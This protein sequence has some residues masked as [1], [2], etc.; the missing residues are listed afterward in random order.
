MS[1]VPAPGAEAEAGTVPSAVP[2][3][4][5]PALAHA[6]VQG[7]LQGCRVLRGC[8]GREAVCG[9][10]QALGS[11]CFVLW[12][13]QGALAALGFECLSSQI[14]MKHLKNAGFHTSHLEDEEQ[15]HTPS[16]GG[17]CGLS[18]C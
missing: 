12:E 13:H 9:D 18:V 3:E 4:P 5:P 7:W 10:S 6:G 17:I 8:A 16:S 11:L 14:T 1:P 15:P 2:I